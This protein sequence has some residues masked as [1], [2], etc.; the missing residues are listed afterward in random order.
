LIK[1]EVRVDP[2]DDGVLGEIHESMVGLA[3]RGFTLPIS[4]TLAS[5]KEPGAIVSGATSDGG[6]EIMTTTAPYS[7]Y[8]WAAFPLPAYLVATDANGLSITGLMP[9]A[10]GVEHPQ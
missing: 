1:Y 2:T 7:A 5:F 3:Q 6:D 8:A 10:E 4:W 9:R